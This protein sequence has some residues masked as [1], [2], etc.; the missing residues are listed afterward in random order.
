M[1]V[2]SQRWVNVAL[3]CGWPAFAAGL[4]RA[5]GTPAER[6]D[7]FRAIGIGHLVLAV[8]GLIVLG[9]AN[10]L[11]HRDGGARLMALLTAGVLAVLNVGVGGMLVLTSASPFVAPEP[12]RANDSAVVRRIDGQG[13][14]VTLP[15]A[16]WKPKPRRTNIADYYH[17]NPPMV[18]G[19]ISA[20]VDGTGKVFEQQ[21]THYQKIAREDPKNT[22]V[23]FEERREND[24]GHPVWFF[25]AEE[26]EGDTKMFVGTAVTWLARSNT[27]VMIFEGHHKLRSDTGIMGEKDLF[28]RSAKQFLLSLN[29][30]P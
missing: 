5:L 23:V 24:H 12:G 1:G 18:A 27:V 28:R 25:L 30:S 20:A 19:V 10:T 16:E 7:I 26:T 29:A 11:R 9:T 21:V 13:F 14:E 15:S 22:V 4:Y 2:R 17:L 6:P 3:A 8:A